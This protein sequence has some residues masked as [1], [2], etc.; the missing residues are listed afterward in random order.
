[1]ASQTTTTYLEETLDDIF[2]LL[3]RKGPLCASQISVELLLP[4]RGVI[5]GLIELQKEGLVELRP[6]RDDTKNGDEELTP[7]GLSRRL[8]PR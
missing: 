5:K 3:K 7:W 6:D 4:L 2:E 8:T 1:M